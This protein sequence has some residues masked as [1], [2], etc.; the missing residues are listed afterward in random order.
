MPLSTNQVIPGFAE[1]LQL[2][3]PGGKAIAV[4][5]GNLA[6]GAM[7]VGDLGPNETLIFEIETVDRQQ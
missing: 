7:G 2:M 6:Y 4:I 3:K 1:M 5:P